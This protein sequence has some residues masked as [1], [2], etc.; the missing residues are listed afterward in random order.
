LY[1]HPPVPLNSV[2]TFTFLVAVVLSAQTTDG[3]VVNEVTS[4][5]FQH[6]STP[7]A[8][9]KMSSDT[10]QDI[11]KSVGLAPKK[12][13]YLVELS[14]KLVS[15]HN[16]TVPAS[17]KA[18][19]SLPGVGH[20]TASVMMSQSFG[21]PAIAVDTHVHR[22]ANRWGLSNEKN[23]DKV[24][25]DLMAVFPEETW[26]KLHLQMIY[27]GREFCTAKDHTP[28]GCPIC[29]LLASTSQL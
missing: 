14:K 22:L 27:F 2:N 26:N 3:K 13:V 10:V 12:A 29:S 19:E 23:V 25:Q 11:I 21:H 4:S 9:S 20:K 18:L 8:M 15:D 1:P 5:L 7:E 17:Y 16:S 24:Q 28:S 6:A